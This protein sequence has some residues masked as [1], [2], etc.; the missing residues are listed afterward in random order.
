MSFHHY[1]FLVWFICYTPPE[2]VM[3][4]R[5]S[6]SSLDIQM[7]GQYG[8]QAPNTLGGGGCHVLTLRCWWMSTCIQR[9]WMLVSRQASAREWRGEVRVTV[10]T[11]WC[12]VHVRWQHI[13]LSPGTVRR[14]RGLSEGKVSDQW[15]IRES[16]GVSAEDTLNWRTQ[17]VHRTSEDTRRQSF[18][19][20]PPPE[21][22]LP[23][24]TQSFPHLPETDHHA[25][26]YTPNSLKFLIRKMNT[27]IYIIQYIH[28]ALY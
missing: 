26:K 13:L 14:A 28:T 10:Y 22:P 24:T 2:P 18:I 19:T 8:T 1:N 7:S 23:Q 3:L 16:K 17:T 4:N 15:L 6:L 9:W 25:S 12:S 5:L 27:Y 21:P 20:P 11:G